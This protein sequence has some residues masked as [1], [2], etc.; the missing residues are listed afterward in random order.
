MWQIF[1]NK[2]VKTFIYNATLLDPQ[3]IFRVIIRDSETKLPFKWITEFQKD[4][5]DVI[6]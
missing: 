1:T 2:Q 5:S 4:T 6:Y 3:T